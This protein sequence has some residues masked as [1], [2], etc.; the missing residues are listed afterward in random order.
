MLF[1]KSHPWNDRV[2]RMRSANGDIMDIGLIYQKLIKCIVGC[3]KLLED[4]SS[5]AISTVPPGV[6]LPLPGIDNNLY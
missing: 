1:F 5:N 3:S 4:F 2:V 6:D